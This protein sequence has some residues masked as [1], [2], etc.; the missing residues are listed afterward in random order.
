MIHRIHG[1][2]LFM[3]LSFSPSHPSPTQEGQL[4]LYEM[5][6]AV[7]KDSKESNLNLVDGQSIVSFKEPPMDVTVNKVFVSESGLDVEKKETILA[8]ETK[9]VTGLVETVDAITR[10][11]GG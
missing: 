11:G 6:G 3:L 9:V 2:P 10:T 7:K 1:V 8:R 4:V 5:K